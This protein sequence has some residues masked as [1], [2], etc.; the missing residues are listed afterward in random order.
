MLLRVHI[1]DLTDSKVL[2]EDDS[3]TERPSTSTDDACIQ[4]VKNLVRANPTLTVGELSYHEILIEKLNLHPAEFVPR[5]VNENQ[6]ESWVNI[7]QEFLDE[8]DDDEIIIKRTITGKRMIMG[9]RTWIYESHSS[10]S[11]KIFTFKQ[12]PGHSASPLREICARNQM[13]PP[14]TTP[15]A[16]IPA[17]FP[18]SQP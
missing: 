15:H 7:C 3:Q 14:A 9:D 17:T 1:V 2:I 4:I 11:V 18:C 16:L 8:A 13:T 12:C 6:K 5:L 10:D